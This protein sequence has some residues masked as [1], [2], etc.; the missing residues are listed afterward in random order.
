MSSASTAEAAAERA[1][2][3]ER[4]DPLGRAANQI[5]PATATSKKMA[6]EL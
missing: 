5:A 4:A 6:H 1:A 3:F 2:S